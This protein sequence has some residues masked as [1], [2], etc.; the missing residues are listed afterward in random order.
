MKHIQSI[1]VRAQ[2]LLYVN[3]D[4]SIVNFFFFTLLEMNK[5]TVKLSTLL[6]QELWPNISNI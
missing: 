4:L 3:N 2:L 6:H 1:Q 5:L